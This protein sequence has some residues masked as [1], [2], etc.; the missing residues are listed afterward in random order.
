MDILLFMQGSNKHAETAKLGTL[1]FCEEAS[2]DLLGADDILKFRLL[3]KQLFRILEAYGQLQR[4]RIVAWG[5]TES[6][7]CMKEYAS[8]NHVEPERHLQLSISSLTEMQ[9]RQ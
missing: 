6:Q 5:S 1:T 3:L 9:S 4:S 2:T 8:A 7:R